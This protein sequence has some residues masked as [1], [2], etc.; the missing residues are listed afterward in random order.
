MEE[1]KTKIEATNITF[2]LHKTNGTFKS[3]HTKTD[4]ELVPQGKLAKLVTRG[5]SRQPPSQP[6]AFR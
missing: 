3:S 4:M 5:S 1:T 6:F 2:K